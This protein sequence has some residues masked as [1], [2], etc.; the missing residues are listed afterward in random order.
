MRFS[1]HRVT[2]LLFT[3]TLL[4]EAALL[5]YPVRTGITRSGLVASLAAA[6]TLLAILLW[7]WR[8]PR[9]LYLAACALSMIAALLPGRP[10]DPTALRAAYLRKLRNYEGTPYIWGGETRRGVDCSGLV[11][12]AMVDALFHEALR[13]TNPGLLRAS[14]SLWWND[15]SAR[16]MAAGYG[17]RMFTQGHVAALVT[18]PI[19]SL[20]PG[21]IAVSP[22]GAH[23]LVCLGDGQWIE[24]DPT[25]LRVETLAPE[26]PSQWLRMNMQII[27][28]HYLT[29]DER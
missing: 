8:I 27:R 10:H 14:L 1:I 19:T 25:D 22:N 23:V 11:R 16:E 21:D 15:A 18:T 29:I 4:G 13:T 26:S 9:F 17:G 2:L 24:A 12:A 5:L 6:V 20:L 7:R 3:A 28:W